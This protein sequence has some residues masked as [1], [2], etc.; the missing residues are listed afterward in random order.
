VVDED[1]DRKSSVFEA[2]ETIQG[3]NYD[4]KSLAF[5]GPK[6][7]KTTQTARLPPFLFYNQ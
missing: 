7:S 3:G 5:C 6:W 1:F 4:L 2:V